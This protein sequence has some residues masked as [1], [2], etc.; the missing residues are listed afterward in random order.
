[1]LGA[2]LSLH[3]GLLAG[4]SRGQATAPLGKESGMPPERKFRPGQVVVVVRPGVSEP[5]VQALASQLQARVQGRIPEYRLYLLELPG[6][7]DAAA[8]KAQV[9]AAIEFLQKQ[10]QVE[11]AFP[12]YETGIPEPLPPIRP[13]KPG[14]GA[15]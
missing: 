8:A 2:L 10:P 7:A 14:G 11:S 12:N 13:R 4:H 1:V 6:T 5:E 9:E 15:G 3:L